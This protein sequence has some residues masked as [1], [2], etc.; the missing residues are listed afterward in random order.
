MS[1]T[2]TAP[3]LPQP[4]L[5]ATAGLATMPAQGEAPGPA[6]GRGALDLNQIEW[7]AGRGEGT[8]VLGP[9]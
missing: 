5:L 1:D 2:G 8:N 4:S 6:Q 7:G 9:P 3:P